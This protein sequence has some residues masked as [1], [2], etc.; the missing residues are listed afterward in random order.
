MVQTIVIMLQ[1]VVTEHHLRRLGIEQLSE[2]FNVRIFD[3]TPWLRP[4]I[5]KKFGHAH[6]DGP[7]YLAVESRERTLHEIAALQSAVVI[8]HLDAGHEQEGLRLALKQHGIM[9]ARFVFG[10]LPEAAT[11]SLTERF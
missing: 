2:R 1:V 6:Y 11:P 3:L 8:D 7:G 10:L 9:R 5:W 4:D